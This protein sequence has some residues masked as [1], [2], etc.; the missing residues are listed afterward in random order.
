[1]LAILDLFHG[2]PSEI[3][4]FSYAQIIYHTM[5][6]QL[7]YFRTDQLLR[8]KKRRGSYKLG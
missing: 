5:R 6:E 4:T 8:T 3:L 2:P 1:M 7:V